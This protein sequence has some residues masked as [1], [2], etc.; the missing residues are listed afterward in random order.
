MLEIY[1]NAYIIMAFVSI[2]SPYES[3]F[4]STENIRVGSY[5]AYATVHFLP[6]IERSNLP[7][8]FLMLS[9]AWTYQERYISRRVVYFGSS[10]LLWDCFRGREC[11]CGGAK[12]YLNGVKKKDLL[13]DIIQYERKGHNQ[14]FS[15]GSLTSISPA[16]KRR[17]ESLWR[18]MVIQYS[19]LQLSWSSDKLPALSGLAAIFQ[20]MTGK[21]YAAGLWEESLI[22]DLCWSCRSISDDTA[23]EGTSSRAPSWSWAST[24]GVIEYDLRLYC[25]P[26]SDG[27]Q[28]CATVRK[29][30]YEPT[31]NADVL[32]HSGFIE[33][34][35]SLLPLE[36]DKFLRATDD[37]Q[38]QYGVKMDGYTGITAPEEKYIVPLCHMPSFRYVGLIV[39]RDGSCME[40]RFKRVGYA[41]TIMSH[42]PEE[43]PEWL[44]LETTTIRIV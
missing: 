16:I 30:V 36:F 5:S 43:Y 38:V 12:F 10:E 7:K 4:F 26:E 34:D 19:T 27:I 13:D 40:T 29:V 33:L 42:R 18:R 17:Q 35:A 41:A 28:F 8:E 11:Q 37:K 1:R 6:S 2:T 20:R 44:K 32:V 22:P 9:R 3:C 23:G 14:A 15:G 31:T 21:T 39:I 25:E 24:D